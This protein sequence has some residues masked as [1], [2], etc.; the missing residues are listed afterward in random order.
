MGISIVVFV[1]VFVVSFVALNKTVVRSGLVVEQGYEE[2]IVTVE[3]DETCE[4]AICELCPHMGV[5]LSFNADDDDEYIDGYGGTVS[6]FYA[7][8]AAQERWEEISA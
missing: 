4:D 2:E 5:C 8:L 3:A 6:E 7:E 1:V